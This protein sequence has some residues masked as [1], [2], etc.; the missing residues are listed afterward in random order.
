MPVELKSQDCS[1]GQMRSRLWK[2]PSTW[3]MIIIISGQGNTCWSRDCHGSNVD[4]HGIAWLFVLAVHFTFDPFD[5]CYSISLII[6]GTSPFVIQA[7]P[8]LCSFQQPPKH[9]R[10]SYVFPHV[11]CISSSVMQS[12]HP[13]C[14]CHPKGCLA[15]LSM[16]TT[17]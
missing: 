4:V 12:S 11:P 16:L 17:Q 9:T 15:S 1:K 13:D 14:K 7:C 10:T 3:A 2:R 8:E 6:W 5:F